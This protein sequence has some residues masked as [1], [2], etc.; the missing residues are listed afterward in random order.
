MAQRAHCSSS[1]GCQHQEAGAASGGLGNGCVQVEQEE[2]CGAGGHENTG[3]QK[4]E[5]GDGEGVIPGEQQDSPV[6]T[7]HTTRRSPLLR[8]TRLASTVIRCFPPSLQRITTKCSVQSMSHGIHCLI[9]IE[10]GRDVI[11]LQRKLPLGETIQVYAVQTVVAGVHAPPHHYSTSSYLQHLLITT[12][13]PHHTAAH[14]SASSAATCSLLQSASCRMV[15]ILQSRCS[16]SSLSSAPPSSSCSSSSSSASSL[17]VG[18]GS[19]RHR[20][21]SSSAPSRRSCCSA[22]SRPCGRSQAT[23]MKAFA[24]GGGA[25]VAP[26]AP[27][28]LRA[29][30]APGAPELPE[31]ARLQRQHGSGRLHDDGPA[32]RLLLVDARHLHRQ[33]GA[34]GA[35]RLL[36]LATQLLPHL[37][38]RTNQQ[39]RHTDQ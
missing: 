30:R 9:H 11:F 10:G 23:A 2:Y 34:Q 19:P 37:P 17:C 1:Q 22:S 31:E 13:P 18:L 27:G 26:D 39:G 6:Q 38:T 15:V 3:G 33:P 12:A 4:E 7:L 5:Q 28:Q 32:L 20:D 24:P 16:R 21:A 8:Q 25:A 36:P 29:P 35:H 14:L